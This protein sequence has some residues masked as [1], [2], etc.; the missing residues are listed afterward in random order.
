MFSLSWHLFIVTMGKWTEVMWRTP[1]PPLYP[2]SPLLSCSPP[3]KCLMYS[4]CSRCTD[5]DGPGCSSMLTLEKASQRIGEGKMDAAWEC[6]C[7]CPACLLCF[8]CRFEKYNN[9]G[10][11]LFATVGYMTVYNYYVYPDKTRPRVR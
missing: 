9:D 4:G 11:T 8:I 6:A 2:S 1:I 7:N 5:R 10:E 3:I